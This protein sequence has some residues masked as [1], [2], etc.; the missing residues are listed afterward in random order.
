[1]NIKSVILG[2]TFVL[3]LLFLV[4]LA[5]PSIV[6]ANSLLFALLPLVLFLATGSTM[7][8]LLILVKGLSVRE[9]HSESFTHTPLAKIVGLLVIA[10]VVT[11]TA[12]AIKS[13]WLTPS[14]AK[15]A[16]EN[17]ATGTLFAAIALV[18]VLSALQKNIY[19]VRIAKNSKLDERQ[20]KERQQVFETSYNV[21][22]LLIIV[23]ALWGADVLY[24]IPN[25]V[26]AHYTY[27]IFPGH[28]K[29]PFY[30]LAVTLF[31]LPL[32]VAA[33]RKR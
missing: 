27:G 28:L 25:L 23:A 10:C 15:S 11:S 12:T 8:S 26:S 5:S 32:V 31:A 19:W 22:A 4:I 6:G 7:A 21:G 14:F 20:L 9:D 18:F 1:M 33:W 2:S 29:Y 17:V 3:W 24:N 30:N 13:L 16:F